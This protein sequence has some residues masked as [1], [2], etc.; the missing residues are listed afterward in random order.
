MDYSLRI[1]QLREFTQYLAVGGLAFV[2]DWSLLTSTWKWGHLNY[3]AATSLGFFVG[4]IVNYV[5]CVFWVWRGTKKQT[6]KDF[7]VFSI[8]GLAGLAVTALG[9]KLGVDIAHFYPPTVKI[10]VAAVVLFWNFIL[11]KFLV[12]SR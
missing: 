12:F 5:L 1:R 3:L 11:R 2:V 4:L 6:P 8:I 7:L 10:A 9:M